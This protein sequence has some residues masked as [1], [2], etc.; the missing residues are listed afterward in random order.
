[1]NNLFIIKF[2]FG[3]E[4]NL[5]YIKCV[6][7]HRETLREGEEK[8]RTRVAQWLWIRWLRSIS[9]VAPINNGMN[10]F[11][12]TWL[13]GCGFIY[14]HE[15]VEKIDGPL[16]PMLVVNLKQNTLLYT[17]QTNNWRGFVDELHLNVKHFNTKYILVISPICLE[18]I[19][20]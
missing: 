17:I 12:S 1:M 2:F 11:K 18:Q 16:H 7:G 3:V 10:L 13:R 5:L 4:D 6:L 8:W 19:N 15:G 20:R 14:F 9:D